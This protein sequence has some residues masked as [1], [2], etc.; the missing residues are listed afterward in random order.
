MNGVMIRR[1]WEEFKGRGCFE[2]NSGSVHVLPLKAALLVRLLHVTGLEVEAPYLNAI[3]ACPL[4][5]LISRFGLSSGMICN[6]TA[7]VLL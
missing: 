5:I 4:F 1:F 3:Y 6:C 7:T 2:D